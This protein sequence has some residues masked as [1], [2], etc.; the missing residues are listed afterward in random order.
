MLGTHG[1]RIFAGQRQTE[2]CKNT[3][4][5][6]AVKRMYTSNSRANR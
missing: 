1:A 5:A 4:V 2:Y 3:S 6:E